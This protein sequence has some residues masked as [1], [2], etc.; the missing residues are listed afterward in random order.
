MANK[1]KANKANTD[2]PDWQHMANKMKA[3][4]CQSGLSVFVYL[5][6]SC[7]PYVVSLDYLY[8]LYLPSSC[9]PY[10]VSLDFLYFPSSCLPYVVSL[11]Y[12]YLIFLYGKQDEGQ[13]KQIQII[14]T[15][16]IWQTRWRQIKQIQII[17]TDNIWQTRWR[18][19]NKYRVVSLDYLY[20][21]YLPSSCLPYVVSLDY[22]YF[23]S[24]CLPYVVSLDYLYLIFFNL[25]RMVVGFT[26]I[27]ARMCKAKLIAIRSRPFSGD[28]TELRQ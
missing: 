21:L 19:I 26:T 20:L 14:Q 7:L 15:N 11:D 25:D 24:S 9:L 16:N 6:S 8:L 3:I 23:P 4:C 2:N 5:P 28:K 17:Q 10:V 22:L 12:L 27:Y 18:Q 1:M 13:T